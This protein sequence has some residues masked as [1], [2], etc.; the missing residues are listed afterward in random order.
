MAKV[1]QANLQRC[2]LAFDLLYARNRDHGVDIA[3]ILEKYHSVS[4]PNSYFLNES[5][6]QNAVSDRIDMLP[7]SFAES[8]ENLKAL[9]GRTIDVIVAGCDAAMPRRSAS[10]HRKPVYWWKAEI[11]LLKAECWRL[12]RQALRSRNRDTGQQNNKYKAAKK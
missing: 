5:A 12:R 9:V 3:L 11:A 2:K 7:D 6:F 8:R 1:L 4:G 10:S